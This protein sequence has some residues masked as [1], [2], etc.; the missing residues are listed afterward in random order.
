MSKKKPQGKL[1]NILKQRKANKKTHISKN[2]V[3]VKT[4]VRGKLIALIAVLEKEEM[5]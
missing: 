4:V 3:F 1:E 5:S 2:I